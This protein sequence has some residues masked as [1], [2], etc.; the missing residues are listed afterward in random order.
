MKK[1]TILILLI[2]ITFTIS[3]K[4]AG[5]GLSLFVPESLYR[6]GDGSISMEQSLEFNLGL[7]EIFSIPMGVTYNTNYGLMVE[8]PGAD[9][10]WFYSDSI[11]PYIMLKAHIPIGPLYFEAFGG[12]AVNYNVT[13]RPLEGNIERDLSTSA[14]QAVLEDRTLDYDKTFGFGYLVGGSVGVKIGKISIDFSAQYRN[15]WHDLNIKAKYSDFSRV[16]PEEEFNSDTT[17]MM[18]GISIGIGG[19]FQF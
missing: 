6:Y 4:S 5:T 18:R 1:I 10:A 11:M 16:S 19:S 9:H 13:L 14:G 3:S 2:S 7:G 15:I 17:L 12:G 8:E